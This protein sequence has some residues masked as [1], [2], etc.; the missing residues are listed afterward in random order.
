MD[1][2]EELG[3]GGLGGV[4]GEAM[5]FAWWW[6]LAVYACG[7]TRGREGCDW[8]WVGSWGRNG[9]QGVLAVPYIPVQGSPGVLREG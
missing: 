6:V 2:R 1:G 5:T 7:G 4:D 8:R 9:I 3:D